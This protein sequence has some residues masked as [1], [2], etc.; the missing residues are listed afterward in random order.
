MYEKHFSL[1]H[2]PFELVPDPDF[3]FLSSTHKKAITYLDYG[4]RENAGFILLTGEIGSGKTT[5][6]RNLIKNLDCNIKLSKISNTKVSSEQLISM[7]ND[8]Y[9]LEIEGKDKIKMLSELNTFLIDRYSEGIHCILLIDEAQNLTPDLLEEIRML[10]NLETAKFKLLKIIFVGQPELRKVISLPELTQLRQRINITYHISALSENETCEYIQH[11]LKIAGNEFAIPCDLEIVEAIFSFSKG[12]PRLINVLCD[13][14]LL[15]AYV[16]GKNTVSKDVI[17]EVI[18]DLDANE[19]WIGISHV[20]PETPSARVDEL[21]GAVSDIAFRTVKLEELVRSSFEQLNG[22]K[23]KISEV[24]DARNEETEEVRIVDS[25]A[26]LEKMIADNS[27]FGDLRNKV[28]ELEKRVKESSTVD[29][30]SNNGIINSIA[31]LNAKL[32]YINKKC[33]SSL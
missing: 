13:F 6:I 31:T 14:A 18:K 26:D 15:S 4:V 5:I 16:D 28:S 11:R 3:L 20:S 8:D 2:K 33:G 12:I 21:N 30:N 10:S 9:G 25:L 17:D 7:I 24:L 23:E 32:D 27:V 22:L 1:K 19:Y 29:E